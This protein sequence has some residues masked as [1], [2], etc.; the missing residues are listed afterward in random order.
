[1]VYSIGAIHRGV[2]MSRMSN[3]RNVNVS[4]HLNVYVLCT[5][6]IISCHLS[7][8]RNTP[9]R[10]GVTH[11]YTICKYIYITQGHRKEYLRG[12]GLFLNG[13]LQKACNCSHLFPNT[14]RT[15]TPQPL[16]IKNHK[17]ADKMVGR[18]T[19]VCVTSFAQHLLVRSMKPQ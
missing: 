5:S 18:Y 2:P 17:V 9:C 12:E 4:C 11:S 14:Y 8:L 1:M 16:P 10:I 15:H 19:S 3:L 13:I 6:K 7:N